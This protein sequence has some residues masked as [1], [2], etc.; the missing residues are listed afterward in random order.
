MDNQEA[1]LTVCIP[2]YNRASLVGTV[3]AL[4]PQ[5]TG[6]VRIK[7]FDNCS[8]TPVAELLAPYLTA[9]ITV[10]RNPVNVGA[11]G[12]IIK[13][14]EYCDTEWMWLLSDD[15]FLA[16]N[17]V[18]TILTT[19]T[20]HPDVAYIK[21]HTDFNG[22]APIQEE[23][24]ATGQPDFIRK[25][26]DFS[27]ILFISSAVYNAREVSQGIKAAYYFAQTFSPQVSFVLAYLAINPLGKVLFSPA[28]IVRWSGPE[29]NAWNF[30]L[31]NKSLSDFVFMAQGAEAR[32]L[33]FDK[34]N[35]RHPI[36]GTFKVSFLQRI[37]KVLMTV[38]FAKVNGK[39]HDLLA[40]Y[41]TSRSF[42][43]WSNTS[44]SFL[45][46]LKM[47]AMATFFSILNLPVISQLVGVAARLAARHLLG[48]YVSQDKLIYNRFAFY[49][50][51]FR[52]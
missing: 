42:I 36:R 11:A 20:A 50:K 35:E 12:N 52:L 45:F 16:E 18:T 25:I 40:D 5:L 51:D 9:A 47:S 31:V 1:V 46:L 3:Q 48:S 43:Y 2:T 38:V 39:Q 15:D 41:F 4:L 10:V 13:C 22:L 49:N 26:K 6:Q 44:S 23:I 19:I 30:H 21:F 24:I 28:S 8:D 34:I 29:S 17:A 37:A 14:F 33:L 27:N 7:I 32:H